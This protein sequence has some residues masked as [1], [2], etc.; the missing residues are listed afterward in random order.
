MMCF[1]KTSSLSILSLTLVP[2]TLR[3]L[4]QIS[5]S[6]TFKTTNS[7]NQESDGSNELE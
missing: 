6:F 7:Y 4:D 2:C 1:Q 3:I 5:R